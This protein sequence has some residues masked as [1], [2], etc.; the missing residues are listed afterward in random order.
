MFSSKSFIIF[1]LKLYYIMKGNQNMKKIILII[2]LLFTIFS[3]AGI[4]HPKHMPGIRLV[5]SNDTK[6]LIGNK[7]Y[8]K[9][10][11]HL[12]ITV[13]KPFKSAGT[14]YYHSGSNKT[15]ILSIQIPLDKVGTHKIKLSGMRYR[16]YYGWSHQTNKMMS[17]V[18]KNGFF[19]V[20]KTDS[21]KHVI[22]SRNMSKI[23]RKNY[24]YF[25][26]K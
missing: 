23:L 3:H 11:Y 4:K 9:Y 22:Y 1:N 21:T 19:I 14:I 18:N 2:S 5:K 10:Q 13:I 17:K 6:S 8:K 24:D 12:I 26:K 7:Y 16:S 25:V 20:A 15:S